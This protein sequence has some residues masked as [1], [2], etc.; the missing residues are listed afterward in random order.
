MALLKLSGVV[1]KISGKI[2]GSVLGTSVNG[3]YIRQNAYSI[4]NPSP[5]QQIQRT[6]IYQVPQEWVNSTA[7]QKSNW[8]TETVNYPYVN[9]VGDS[10]F[11]TAY[12]LFN[13]INQNRLLINLALIANPPVYSAPSVIV[14]SITALPP[15]T[16][17]LIYSAVSV[18]DTLVIYATPPR[19]MGTAYNPSLLKFVEYY[20]S[21]VVAGTR[22]FGTN[23]NNLFGNFST[24]QAIY[25]VVKVV[26]RVTGIPSRP[27]EPILVSYPA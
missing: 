23:Y 9:R 26:N 13:Y 10:V 22:N 12:Q 7:L 15:S 1:T 8:L 24:G 2:G 3:S 17:N 5:S 19:P 25:V 14:Y 21:V 18:T 27:H 6:K 4:K 16:L 20:D 11:Y